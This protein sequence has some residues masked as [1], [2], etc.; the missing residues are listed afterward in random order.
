MARD[1]GFPGTDAQFDFGR[2]RRRRALSRLA[3]R[4]RRSPDD[5]DVILPF[6][7]VVEALGRKGERSLG[8]QVI[9]LD[10]IVGTVDRGR[11]FDRSFR[12]TS[13]RVR[14]R[15][16]R[17]AEAQRR[18]HAMPPIDVYRV[19]ELHFV[20]DGHHRVSVARAQGLDKLDAY[21]TEVITEVGPEREIRLADLPLKSHERLFHERVP[22]P[23][24]ARE[25]IA[26]SSRSA[27]ATLAES[28]EAWGLRAM[29]AAGE[30]L[31]R[32][33]VAEMWF[34]DEY[35]PVTEMLREAGI[36]T[37]NETDAYTAVISL[38]YLLLRTHDWDE[39]V[40]DAL[41]EQMRSPSWEDTEVR[42]LRRTLT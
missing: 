32:E 25:R 7:E 5:V 20:K 33:Q 14:R 22:L 3:N 29:Q 27:Y 34:R 16:E 28:V 13:G 26:P 38:R 39:S 1:T 24:E 12:P 42:R 4:L 17:I 30:F 40:L 9:E 37:E 21:V 35:L 41:R 6:E 8:L 36:A 15:W 31:T 11:E 23:P 2:A 19:G 10:S 18:G